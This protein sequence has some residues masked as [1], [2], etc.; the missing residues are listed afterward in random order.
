MKI[1]F[2]KVLYSVN[3]MVASR[4][5]THYNKNRKEPTA[6]KIKDVDMLLAFR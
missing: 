4:K 1:P 6:P 3:T 2:W 5:G